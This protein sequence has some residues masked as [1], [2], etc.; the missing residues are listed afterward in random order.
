MLC[1]SVKAVSVYTHSLRLPSCVASYAA[2]I[3]PVIPTCII[4]IKR[5]RVKIISLPAPERGFSLLPV[6]PSLIYQYTI[7][8]AEESNLCSFGSLFYKLNFVC[9]FYKINFV[10]FRSLHTR[11]HRNCYTTQCE[12]GRSLYLQ[13]NI[14]LQCCDWISARMYP[15]VDCTGISDISGSP[16]W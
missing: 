1:K 8:F 2:S 11:L 13:K 9:I 6:L 5:L 4:I 3:K 16:Q 10:S 7:F 14:F 12:P 15:L